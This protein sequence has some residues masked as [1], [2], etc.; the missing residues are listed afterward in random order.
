M[1]PMSGSP[2]RPGRTGRSAPERL[3]TPTALVDT[4]SARPAPI[5]ATLFAAVFLAAATPAVTRAAFVDVTDPAAGPALVGVTYGLGWR[6]FDLDGDP[7][8][9]VCRHYLRPVVFRN[10][11]DGTIAYPFFPQLFE[12]PDDH[13]GGLIADFDQ[14]GDPD[15]YLTGGADAGAST[16]SKKMY[17]N[18]GN[19]QFRNV[20]SAWGLADSLARGRAS[21]AMDVDADGD[22]D[23]FVAKASR[24]ASPNSLFLN[25]GNQNFTDVA[26][27]AGVA[28]DFGCVGGIWADYDRDGDPDLLIGGEEEFTFETRL[29]RNDG[30]VTFTDVTSTVLPGIGQIAA[31]AFGDYDNDGDLDLAAGLGDRGLFDGMLWSAD[32]LYFF[33]NTQ[34]GDNGLDGIA[35][36]QTGDSATYNL[37]LDGFF[38]PD[39]IWISETGFH[40][41]FSPFT[42][43]FEIFNAPPFDPGVSTGFYLWTSP[44]LQTWQMRCSAPPEGQTSFAGVIRT[45]GTITGA[46]LVGAE[47][48]TQGPRGTR[49]WRNDGGVFTDVTIAAGI[50]DT[51]NVH[52]LV[53]VDLDQDG[54]LDLYALNKGDTANLNLPDVFYR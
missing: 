33:F 7:D 43:P 52:Q 5:R 35:F 49:L 25:D 32:S 21:S 12:S 9:F 2:R 8:A 3:R 22:V 41:Q 6:D 50:T 19:F 42:L 15:I 40:P 18:D 38:Q 20:A 17:R 46:S 27:A 11:G 1:L 37:A 51:T 16:V 24:I 30:A 28:D 48:F 36:T 53:W 23:L 54:R 10:G 4:P 26:A 31:A 14:D 39:S 34:H 45:N 13:H 44:S 29:Y 47:P